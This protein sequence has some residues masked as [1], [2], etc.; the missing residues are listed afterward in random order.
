MKNPA[1]NLFAMAVGED[2]AS[3]TALAGSISAQAAEALLAKQKPDGHILFELEADATIPAEYIFLN[4]FLDD[5]KPEV[6]AE[7]GTYL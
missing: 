6:E 5:L 7:L 3:L 4:H 2:G 1:T